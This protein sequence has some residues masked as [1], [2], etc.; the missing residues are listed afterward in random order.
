MRR[1]YRPDWTPLDVRYGPYPLPP[2]TAPPAGLDRMLTAAKDLGSDF[3]CI[4]I[5][6]YEIDGK[7][8]FGEFT[9][10]PCGGLDRFIPASFD[11]ELG[12]RWK[13]PA[14]EMRGFAMR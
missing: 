7:V 11:N 13:L 6:L 12:A 2:V 14:L 9:P 8:F 4:R 5:D 10:Y 1:L 3:D